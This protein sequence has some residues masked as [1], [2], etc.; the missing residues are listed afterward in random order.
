MWEEKPEAALSPAQLLVPA[1]RAPLLY[2][3]VY[4]KL[5]YV[6]PTSFRPVFVPRQLSNMSFVGRKPSAW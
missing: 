2:P 4:R 5:M 1:C 3:A 6:L